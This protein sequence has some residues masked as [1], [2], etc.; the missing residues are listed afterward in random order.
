MTLYATGTT[1]AGTPSFYEG[2]V[3]PDGFTEISA[4]SYAAA[5][6]A[7]MAAP[8]VDLATLKMQLKARIDAAAEAARLRVITPGS[9]QAME[10]Q[11]AY[12]EA[13]QVDAALKASASATFDATAYPMLAASVGFDVDPQTGKPTIDVAGEA[14][15]VLAA[16]DAYQRVGAAIRAVRLRG[17][18]AIE[19]AVDADAAQDAFAAV[20]FSI[21]G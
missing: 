19:A 12:A 2:P 5:L 14:R 3:V 16:Y 11:E 17:K 18:A 7:A 20:T 1:A 13:V 8:T 4:E 21:G 15:A 6:A 10:Y 9:G